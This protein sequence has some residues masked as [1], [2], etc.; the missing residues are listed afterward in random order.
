M[1]TLM[2]RNRD[3]FSILKCTLVFTAIVSVRSHTKPGGRTVFHCFSSKWL[4]CLATVRAAR[5][6]NYDH[7]PEIKF[8]GCVRVQ[9]KALFHLK[10]KNN[11]ITVIGQFYWWRTSPWNDLCLVFGGNEFVFNCCFVVNDSGGLSH[12]LPN[13]HTKLHVFLVL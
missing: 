10:E 2:T 7:F 13:H 1:Q 9:E 3:Q 4:M 8:A 5:L 12:S 6:V 11:L